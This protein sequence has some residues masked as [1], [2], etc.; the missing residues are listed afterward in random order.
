[1]EPLLLYSGAMLCSKTKILKETSLSKLFSSIAV[2][3]FSCTKTFLSRSLKFRIR[4]TLLKLESQT[5]TSLT[6]QYSVSFDKLLLNFAIYLSI[7][8]IFQQGLDVRLYMNITARISERSLFL[9]RLQFILKLY[10]VT[11]V[12]LLFWGLF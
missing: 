12:Y 7:C 3:L 10:Q 11:T 1:M 9:I 6:E 8:A 5:L 4:S 2:T